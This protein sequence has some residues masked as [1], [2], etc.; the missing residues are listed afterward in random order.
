[1]NKKKIIKT[2]KIVCFVLGS[3]FFLAGCRNADDTGQN[4]DKMTRPDTDKPMPHLTDPAKELSG[5]YKGTANMRMDVSMPLLR[6]KDKIF[7]VKDAGGGRVLLSASI[8]PGTM[9][10]PV[11]YNPVSSSELQYAHDGYFVNCAFS[12]D[13]TLQSGKKKPMPN[14]SFALGRRSCITIDS[15][16]KY[17]LVLYYPDLKM[18]DGRILPGDIF[19]DGIKE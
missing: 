13:V 12:I 9:P 15:G 10:L 19:F 8:K 2:A 4:S 1:M 16:G 11:N 3:A 6:Y 7:T 17:R 18:A 14:F 5:S